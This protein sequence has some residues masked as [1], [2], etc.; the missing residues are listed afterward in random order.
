VKATGSVVRSSGSAKQI[1]EIPHHSSWW[2]FVF[3]VV[4][5]LLSLARY[6]PGAFNLSKRDPIHREAKAGG[7]GHRTRRVFEP[8]STDPESAMGFSTG[9]LSW[10]MGVNRSTN[11]ASLSLLANLPDHNPSENH[12]DHSARQYHPSFA[13]H[14]SPLLLLGDSV[15]Y[16]VDAGSAPKSDL[17]NISL[18]H[19]IVEYLPALSKILRTSG[20]S[21]GG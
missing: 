12:H 14:E 13:N 11:S 7:K 19:K 4:K 10:Q 15:A 16:P 2:S 9:Y 21:I 3:F 18:N 20:C 17:Q 5:S 8:L 1:P 6:P